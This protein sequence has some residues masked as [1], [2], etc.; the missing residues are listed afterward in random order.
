MRFR[1][2]RSPAMAGKQHVVR[3]RPDERAELKRLISAGTAPA[4]QLARARILLKADAGASGPRLSDR[5]VATA[6][7]V[8][9][10]TVARVRADFT[11]GGLTRAL[12]RRKPR[13]TYA[14]RLDGAAEAHLIALS[15]APPPAGRAHWTLRLLADRLVALE[16]V[17][18]V[19]PETVRATL[20]KTSSSRGGCANGC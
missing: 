2:E 20:K 16:L 8:S 5:Q 18:H 6:V 12:A 17:D 19:C 15:C 9:A 3:L 4:R 1:E 11:T 7:E 14:R 10:R 13:R